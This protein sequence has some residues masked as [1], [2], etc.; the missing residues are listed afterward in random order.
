MMRGRLGGKRRP[1]VPEVVNNPREN[2]SG[3]LPRDMAGRRIPPKAMMVRPVAPVN[4]VKMEQIM[5]AMMDRPPGSQPRTASASLNTLWGA[6]LSERRYPAKAK[7]GM[8]T[9]IGV[10]AMR[11]ISMIMAEESMPPKNKKRR[12]APEM[13]IKRGVPKNIMKRSIRI[14]KR[15]KLLLHAHVFSQPS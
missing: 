11:Y 7:R 15:V 9:R 14:K 12:A 4:A 6:L 10:V 5:R 1:N 8:A 13:T 2:V 3:Y